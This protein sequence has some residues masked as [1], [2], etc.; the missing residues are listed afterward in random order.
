MINPNTVPLHHNSWIF[1]DPSLHHFTFCVVVVV[2]VVV[3]ITSWGHCIELSTL[4]ILSLTDFR[5]IRIPIAGNAY[6]QRTLLSKSRC[7]K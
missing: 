5:R 4:T 6:D 2:V 7:S 1:R 3:I